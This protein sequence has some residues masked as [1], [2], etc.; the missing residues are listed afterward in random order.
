MID[1]IIPPFYCVFNSV[2]VVSE[3][4][5][6]EVLAELHVEVAGDGA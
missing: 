6:Q 3:P 1:E 2:R 4:L 5:V